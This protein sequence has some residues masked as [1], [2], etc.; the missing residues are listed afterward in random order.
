MERT[1]RIARINAPVSR[2]QG[3]TLARMMEDMEVSRA[4]VNRDLQLMRDQTDAWRF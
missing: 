2:P 4:T 3:A 1:Q